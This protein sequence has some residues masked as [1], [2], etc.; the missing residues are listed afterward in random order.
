MTALVPYDFLTRVFALGA[1]FMGDYSS[2]DKV[3]SK[4]CR[5]SFF[6]DQ[7][8]MYCD[9]LYACMMSLIYHVLIFLTSF[10][11]FRTV[12]RWCQKS[13]SAGLTQ[14]FLTI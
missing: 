2:N 1:P 7:L 12:A 14:Y 6:C 11:C 9:Q 4:V 3:S 8:Y 10:I 5:L 13:K